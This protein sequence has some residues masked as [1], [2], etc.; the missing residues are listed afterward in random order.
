MHAIKHLQ[1]Y[2]KMQEFWNFWY[3]SQYILFY[4][5][6]YINSISWAASLAKTAYSYFDHDSKKLMHLLLKPLE[7]FIYPNSLLH[8]FKLDFAY[9][10]AKK[11]QQTGYYV[12]IEKLAC[13]L[14]KCY[15]CKSIA[16]WMS[17]LWERY[18]KVYSP[19]IMCNIEANFS[20]HT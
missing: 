19:I 3:L 18:C 8:S 17:V 12:Y 10:F 14:K 7:I 20:M 5:I 9:K 16:F 11:I 13:K 6:H 1:E 2:M 4:S 15:S